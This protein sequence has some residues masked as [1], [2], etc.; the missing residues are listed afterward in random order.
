[1]KFDCFGITSGWVNLLE[2]FMPKRVTSAL[3]A[4]SKF[5][6]YV[7]SGVVAACLL[8]TPLYAQQMPSGQNF[9]GFSVGSSTGGGLGAAG[10]LPALPNIKS[11]EQSLPDALKFA[12][13][14][15][16]LEPLKPNDF[17][18][19]VLQT[20]GQRLPIFGY[21][22][23]ENINASQVQAVGAMQTTNAFAPAEG[24][25][26]SPDYP[27]GVGDQLI[28]RAWGSID[29]D[30][31]VT[32]DRNGQVIIPKVGAVSMAGIKVSQ[33]EAVIK[34]ALAKNFCRA[35]IR[36]QSAGNN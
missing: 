24:T 17:Q 31:R 11:S 9:G 30:V 29:V 5:L 8:A 35:C 26:V 6:F 16:A 21:Q 7:A 19:F 22:F 20:T 34:Q 1:M 2:F 14:S 33:S 28:I 12:S 23:F 32:I 18:Q 10:A 25:A 15:I 3:T 36:S 27:L 4:T 13:R